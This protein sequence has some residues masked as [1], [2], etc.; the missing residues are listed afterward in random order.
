MKFISFPLSLANHGEEF[1]FGRL[2]KICC[3][4]FSISFF[5]VSGHLNHINIIPLNV[6]QTS[7]G[8]QIET[9]IS[10]LKIEK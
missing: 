8:I 7:V 2:R 3:T 6:L 9:N 4:R 1:E 10:N 5:L